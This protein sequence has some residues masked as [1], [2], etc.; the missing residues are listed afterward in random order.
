VEHIVVV[1]GGRATRSIRWP[2]GVLWGIILVSLAV[3]IFWPEPS[4]QRLGPDVDPVARTFEADSETAHRRLETGLQRD[5]RKTLFP[6][7]RVRTFGEPAPGRL[8]IAPGRL[9]IKTHKA[10]NPGLTRYA[11]RS[12]SDRM[13]DLYV[14]IGSQTWHA[15]YL[16]GRESADFATDFLVQID[17]LTK[18]RTRVEVIE[19]APYIRGART[20][21]VCGR[22]LVPEVGRE[23]VPVAPT[24]RDRQE[25]LDVVTQVIEEKR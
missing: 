12:T 23:K 24:T 22:H 1:G 25:V 15:E 21:R 10:N 14:T 8:I 6:D 7:A 16:R 5:L 3:W 11:E 20:G 2:R 4:I 9:D 18:S 17:P 13:R 19:Y